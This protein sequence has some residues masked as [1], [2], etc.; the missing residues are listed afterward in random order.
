MS[1]SLDK[2]IILLFYF[3]IIIL[4]YYNG[5]S[6][7]N[8]VQDE[9]Q[10]PRFVLFLPFAVS[11]LQI[12]RIFLMGRLVLS[13]LAKSWVYIFIYYLLAFIIGST[14]GTIHH[15]Y[16]TIWFVICPPITWMYFSTVINKNNEVPV[17]L[18]KWSFWMFLVFS[19]ISLYYIPRSIRDNGLFSSL[20]TGYYVIFSYPLVLL[21]NAR[22]KKIIATVL[23][24]IV[25][26]LSLKR[27]GIVAVVLGFSLYFL[28]S[29]NKHFV[30]KLVIAGVAVLLL[31]Y[32]LPI[33]N[34]YTNGTLMV[35]YEFTQNQGDEDGR[36][37]MYPIVW[38]SVWDS[39]LV[40]IL[41]GHGHNGVVNDNV[42][43]GLSAHN[44]YLEFL[45]DYGV[46][47]L[48][49]LLVYQVRLF[50]ITIRSHK[51]KEGFLS[52]IFALT[53]IVVLSMVSI[54]FSYY[55]FL[56]IIPFWCVIDNRLLGI[57]NLSK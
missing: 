19:V 56:L 3:S 48:V 29:S 47:G 41:V 17:F 43:H 36:A 4:F 31:I 24:I 51:T 18:Q 15:N 39:S 22:W 40:H 49:L 45:Y 10:A 13:P 14:Q 9:F 7:S 35:R 38:K 6:Q 20:N 1:K 27:G 26:F 33:I 8:T 11:A 21:D 54:V 42:L 5:L 44:D 53:C 32:T 50:R 12:L 2:F 57:N 30:R 16:N 46:F 34:E 23:L 52:T 25:V 37:S 28:L 55:Y